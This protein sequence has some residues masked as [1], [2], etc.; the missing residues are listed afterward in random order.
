[1]EYV[2]T[3]KA[4]QGKITI[5]L[6]EINQN[7]LA[8][9]GRLKRYRQRVKQNRQNRTFPKQ[10]KE[11][12][13]TSCGEMTQK[14]TNN[15]MQEKPKDFGLKYGNQENIRKKAEWIRQHDKKFMTR[16]RP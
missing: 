6:E 10:L 5:Q 8:K 1:M 9:E 11:I 14:H 13:P 3:K 4:T 15:R 2:E 12:L 7:V 16:R